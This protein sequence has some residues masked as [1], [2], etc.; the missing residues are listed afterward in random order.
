MEKWKK[1]EGFDDYSVSTLGRVRC[2]STNEIK[3][4]NLVHG[5]AYWRNKRVHRL[6]AIAFI[7]NPENK[8]EVNHRN[9]IKHDNRVENLEWV[10]RS[11]NIKYNFDVLYKDTYSEKISNALK[12]RHLSDEHKLKISNS[13]KGRIGP[14]TGRK[15]TE[16]QRLKVSMALKGRHRDEATKAKI[17]ASKK[18][19]KR[20]PL[21]EEQKAK[22]SESVRLSWIKRKEASA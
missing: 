1:I 17:S 8:P 6:V 2:D 4:I 12:G 19:K 21:S 5:Y 10:T 13:E 18:G 14:M 20:A 16:E 11:E 22:L 3:N 15:L 9:G 7:P